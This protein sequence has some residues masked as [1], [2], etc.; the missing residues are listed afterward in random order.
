MLFSFSLIKK[1]AE[2]EVHLMPSRSASWDAADGQ[3]LDEVAETAP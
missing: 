3:T 2:L 1:A